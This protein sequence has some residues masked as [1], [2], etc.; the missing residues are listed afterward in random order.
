[1]AIKYPFPNIPKS[2]TNGRS[3]SAPKAW[4]G[5][6]RKPA[7]LRGFSPA[8]LGQRCPPHCPPQPG[9]NAAEQGPFPSLL[10]RA[11]RPARRS[12]GEPL[13]IRQVAELFGCSPWTVR[14]TLLPR[15]FPHFR[16]SASG[17]LIF[18]RDQI[19]RWIESQQEGGQTTK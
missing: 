6:V 11:P 10:G 2:G 19:E 9:A 16:F 13:S 3:V 5:N 17:R 14:Q 4:V 18:F 15:G 8:S 1:M 7:R 12:L